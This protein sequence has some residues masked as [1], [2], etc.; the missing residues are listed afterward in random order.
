M[1]EMINKLSNE[2]NISSSGGVTINEQRV[3]GILRDYLKPNAA[4]EIGRELK[5]NKR[6][7]F[8]MLERDKGIPWRSFNEDEGKRPSKQMLMAIG[9][10]ADAEPNQIK[11]EIR[12]KFSNAPNYV[13]NEEKIR[14]WKQQVSARESEMDDPNVGGKQQ[15]Q[16]GV[17]KVDPGAV[18]TCI[19]QQ[20]G[21]RCYWWGWQ[22]DIPDRTCAQNFADL[23]ISIGVGTLTTIIKSMVAG[24]WIAAPATVLVLFLALYAA[25]LGARIRWCLN[26]GTR[27]VRLEGIWIP[28]VW[29]NRM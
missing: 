4:N 10:R 20:G 19:L 13:L 27:G 22:H 2:G 8:A 18:A 16:S 26:F 14:R 9:I 29:A 24:T 25:I 17:T 28:S 5:A 6:D 21:W 11:E 15:A 12:R 7:G 3:D 23:L 1:G